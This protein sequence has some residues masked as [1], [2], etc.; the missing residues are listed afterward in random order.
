MSGWRNQE[1]ISENFFGGLTFNPGEASF[2]D[3][4]NTDSIGLSPSADS[5]FA[6]ANTGYFSRSTSETGGLTDLIS[7]TPATQ[8]GSSLFKRGSTERR[9]TLRANEDEKYEPIKATQITTEMLRNLRAKGDEKY[10]PMIETSTPG[11]ML[12]K[13]RAKE[14]EK[15]EPMIKIPIPRDGERRSSRN[16][17]HEEGEKEE[18][19]QFRDTNV[20]KE[21]KAQASSSATSVHISDEAKTTYTPI[22]REMLREQGNEFEEYD[23]IRQEAQ[24]SS[25]ATSWHFSDEAKTTYTPITRD[26]ERRSSRK[27]ADEEGKGVKSEQFPDTNV[28]KEPKDGER[29]SSRKVADEEGKG[30]KSEQFPETIIG[31]IMSRFTIFSRLFSTFSLN[32]KDGERRSSRKVAD[33]EGKGVKSEQFPDTNVKKEP[34]DGERRSSRKVADEEGKGVKSEQFPDTNVKKEPKVH[35][36]LTMATAEIVQKS[37]EATFEEMKKCFPEDYAKIAADPHLRESI[38]EEATFAAREQAALD[39]AFLNRREEVVSVLAEF[40]SMDRIQLIKES[41]TIPT[42]DMT[43]EIIPDKNTKEGKGV[44][45]AKFKMED[46]EFLPQLEIKTRDGIK[47]A[48]FLQYSSIA[49]ETFTFATQAVGIKGAWSKATMKSAINDTATRIEGSSDVQ[50]ALENFSKAWRR[51]GSDNWEKARA[52]FFL[53]KDSHTLGLLWT[54]FKSLYNRNE[55]S[56]REWAE[57]FVKV[58]AMITAAF[59]SP[60]VALTAKFLL[61]LDQGVRWVKKISNVEELQE[62]AKDLRAESKKTA[63]GCVPFSV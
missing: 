44:M 23:P 6:A 21:P 47:R 25:S 40:L 39:H 28:K 7:G 41:L 5:L 32:P 19:E 30:V 43:L 36:S 59:A 63:A 14:D 38:T 46:E 24:A 37:V 35:Q 22:T 10:E 58:T 51:A 55:M 33:E 61:A 9:W 57:T 20:N 17:M 48:K 29:R 52:G 13:L 26:G 53:L 15:Y 34:K 18:S 8:Q 2:S 12:R 1:G 56:R 49:I 11:E 45:F 54:I 50:E 42:F 3:W 27:V 62:F 60:G 4:T 16:V 31:S